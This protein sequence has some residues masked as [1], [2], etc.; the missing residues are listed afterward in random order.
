MRK[1]PQWKEIWSASSKDIEVIQ[2]TKPWLAT[3]IKNKL[4]DLEDRSRWNNL[5]INGIIG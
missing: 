2:N 3:E 1:Y 4:V 5:R